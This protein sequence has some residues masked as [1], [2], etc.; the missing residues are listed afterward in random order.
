MYKNIKTSNKLLLGALALIVAGMI[1]ANIFLKTKVKEISEKRYDIE[2]SDTLRND[3]TNNVIQ[4]RI[5]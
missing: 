4:I 2:Q 1:V 3:S 5:N